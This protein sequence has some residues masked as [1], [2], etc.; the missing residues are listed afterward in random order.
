MMLNRA[1]NVVFVSTYPPRECGLAT[2]TQDLVNELEDIKLVNKPKVIAISNGYYQYD[3][4]VIMEIYQYERDSYIKAAKQLN[5]TDT[6]LVVIEHEYGIFGGDWGDYI[7]DFTDNLNIPFI[8]TLHTVLLE[9]SNKQKEIIKILA[10]KSQKVVTMA[11]NTVK[12]L[13][14]V[15]GIDRGKIEV[16]PHGVPYKI[17]EPRE[18][19]K[20]RYGFKG[21]QIISTFGLISPGKGL[22][23]GI[24]AIA[25]VAKKHPDVLYLILGQTHPCVKKEYGESYRE[26]LEEL[27]RRLGVETNV[28]FVNKYLTKDEVIQYLQLSDIYMT[29]YLSREQAVSGT[30]AY[31]VGYGKV[32]VSTP[33]PYAKEM[34]ADGR[35]MLAEFADSE[36]LA[37][38][39]NYILD[40]PEVQSEM[41]KKT[42]AL[43][44]T[45]TWKNV[46]N[47]Y[48]RLFMKA[49]EEAQLKGDMLVG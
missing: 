29:P 15:Y 41:E 38:C 37:K 9:P 30:L 11:N 34:L 21:R 8:T 22:E 12:I 47:Q 4:R 42:L 3:D 49:I 7:F 32:I 27:V 25:K 20:E 19:L 24:E 48:A 14:E 23:Y 33:Y 10:E 13:T 44:R 1:R 18:K 2:F 45:M 26:K 43:G 6:E 17:V 31:A 35:G 5:E 40:H 36:S 28:C 39:I 16:I 46:A